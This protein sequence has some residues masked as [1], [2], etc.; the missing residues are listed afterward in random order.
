MKLN[1]IIFALILGVSV[2]ACAQ[3]KPAAEATQFAPSKAEADSVSYLVGINFGSFLKSYDW[4][5]LNYSE[6]VKGMKE[7]V[8]AK[9]DF[10]DPDFTEQFKIDPNKMNDI[11]NN[12][13]EKRHTMAV[14][15]NKA[16]GAKY[17]EANAKKDGVQTTES[18]LQYKI[19]EE[20]NKDMVPGPRDT[21]SVIY[22]GTLTDGTVFDQTP[23]G[24]EPATL[25]LNRVIPGWTEG[26]Q[27]IGEGGKIQLTIP[28]NLGYGEQGAQAIQPNSTLLFDVELVKV[29]KYVEPVA[30]E[31]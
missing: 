13:L 30:E 12:Y 20:G 28:S 17:L 2:A 4:G 23:E 11:F 10:R 7:F 22:K 27:L 14:E 25:V 26:L 3:N 29:S 21:V 16:K 31:E 19:I 6:I 9:G 8:N 5:D 1:K 18:G 24:A 15:T